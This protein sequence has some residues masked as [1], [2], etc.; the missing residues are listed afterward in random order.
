MLELSLGIVILKKLRC[1]VIEKKRKE[2]IVDDVN[3]CFGGEVRLLDC[4]KVI[5]FV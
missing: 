4:R 2:K 3:I 1:F 5:F